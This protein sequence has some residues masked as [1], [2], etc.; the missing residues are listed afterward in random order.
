MVLLFPSLKDQ[1]YVEKIFV[2]LT[3]AAAD[4]IIFIMGSP[5]CLLDKFTSVVHMHVLFF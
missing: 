5:V 4:L 3:K 2:S 1:K